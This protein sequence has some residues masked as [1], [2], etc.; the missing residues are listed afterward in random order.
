LGR[1]TRNAVRCQLRR[2]VEHALKL[3]HSSAEEPRAG[4]MNS[5]DEG[6]DQIENLVTPSLE[7]DL[8]EQLPHPFARTRRRIDRDL[9]AHGETEAADG[10]PEACPYGLEQLL[11]EEWLP[12]RGHGASDGI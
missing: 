2:I 8:E 4:W 1:S 12:E 5:I 11:D 7:R 3:E 9:G 6:R 10:L